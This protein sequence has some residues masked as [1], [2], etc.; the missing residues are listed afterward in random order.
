MTGYPGTPAAL[1]VTSSSL[2]ESLWVSAPEMLITSEPDDE[3]ST[4]C[5]G[6]GPSTVYADG[7][8]IVITTGDGAGEIPER[9]RAEVVADARK[10]AVRV[11]LVVFMHI[12]HTSH[13]MES[14][15]VNT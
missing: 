14:T 5:V 7:S 3:P 12:R 2:P 13:N 15:D 8:I 10:C 4:S 1:T 11:K 6:P 9:V